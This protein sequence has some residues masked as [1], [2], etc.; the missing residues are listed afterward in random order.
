MQ[1][2]PKNSPKH[3]LYAD[4]PSVNILPHLLYH[5]VPLPFSLS[6]IFFPEHLRASCRHNDILILYTVWIFQEQGHSF[7]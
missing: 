4:S 2:Y 1:I 5:A 7:I 6:L 3:I